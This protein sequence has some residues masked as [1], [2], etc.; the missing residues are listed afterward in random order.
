M[1]QVTHFLDIH[2]VSKENLRSMIDDAIA[3]KKARAG[4]PKGTKDQDISLAGHTL[5]A[6]FDFPSTRTRV[7]FDMAMRQLGGDTMVLNSGDMQLGR[8][9]TVADLSRVQVR[10]S[11]PPRATPATGPSNNVIS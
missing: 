4:F 6:I 3:V 9:E 2:E 8:G 1:T 11:K 7:S 5:A 10:K